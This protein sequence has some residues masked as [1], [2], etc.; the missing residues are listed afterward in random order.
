MT[1]FNN[2]KIYDKDKAHQEY[3]QKNG[4]SEE[5]YLQRMEPM[6][7]GMCGDCPDKG[8]DGDYEFIGR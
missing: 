2:L 6:T 5:E 7:D 1:I 8:Y 3:L 4:I